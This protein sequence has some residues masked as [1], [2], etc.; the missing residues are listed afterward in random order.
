M[1]EIRW[2]HYSAHVDENG[3]SMVGMTYPGYNVISVGGFANGQTDGNENCND[4][5]GN[6]ISGMTPAIGSRVALADGII[7]GAVCYAGS[8]GSTLRT[9]TWAIVEAV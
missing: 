5:G 1:P 7:H 8:P 6:D 4:E 3:L 9:H 2:R